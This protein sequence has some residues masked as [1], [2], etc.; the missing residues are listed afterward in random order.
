MKDNAPQFDLTTQE[1]IQR[2]YPLFAAL[3]QQAPV[4]WNA[5]L[6]GW[7]V[8]RYEDVRLGL[9][10]RNLSVEKMAGFAA[11]GHGDLQAKIAFLTDIIGG[12][13]VFKDPPNHTRL[14]QVLQGAFLPSQIEKLR[15][16]V[17]VISGDLLDKA[18][19]K[20]LADG[21]IDLIL[22]YAFPL[23]AIVIGELCGVPA[24]E[25]ER[26]KFWADDIGKFVLQGRAT[27]DKYDRSYKALVE[28][29]EFYRELVREHR[30]EE[31]DD[32]V[33]LMMKSHGS[34]EPLSDDEI[35]STLVLLLFA[36]HETTTNL[37]A[38]GMLR[39]IENR[40]QMHK[41]RHDPSLIDGAVEEF[42]RIEGPAAVVVRIAKNTVKIGNHEV[43]AGERVFFALNSADHDPELFENPEELNVE[44]PKSKHMAFG[45]G[46]HTCL[47]APLARMEGQ[48]AFRMLLE[49]FETIK[50][51][52]DVPEWRD[53]L[54]TR[55][56]KSLPAIIEP[57]R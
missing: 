50:L 32:L 18:V 39:L 13:M 16:K 33:G 30:R 7:L 29:V 9:M 31:K 5:S 56:L 25:A 11:R 46:I 34:D 45:L 48:V 36:G 26:L 44:R 47:G 17:E 22:D 10:N 52:D 19:A 49:R 15:K 2:P 40:D 51:I 21:K 1:A 8:T 35:V 20:Q 41:L 6:K 4:H 37:I 14:R 28:C 43:Q 54:I 27:P 42:L 3:R 53:E 23:P 57:C 12:W 55:G 24:K 38:N